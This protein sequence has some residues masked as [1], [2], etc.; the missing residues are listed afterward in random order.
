M[1]NGKGYQ[2]G[3]YWY[4]S[5]APRNLTLST[6]LTL[7]ITGSSQ[8]IG[9]IIL[10]DTATNVIISWDGTAGGNAGILGIYGGPLWITRENSGDLCTLPVYLAATAG[11]A[12]VTIIEL[13]P[14]PN[15]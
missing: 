12:H 13:F 11:T 5:A 6:A 9:Y 14:V 10:P 2:D 3:S 4:S 7:A 15:P 8:R 1:N